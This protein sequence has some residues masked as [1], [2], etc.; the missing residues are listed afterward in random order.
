PYFGPALQ[1]VD[2]GSQVGVSSIVHDHDLVSI[3]GK[4]EADQCLQ[5]FLKPARATERRND[6]AEI[7]PHPRQAPLA[8]PVDESRHSRPGWPAQKAIWTAG[9]RR[10]PFSIGRAARKVHP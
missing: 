6:D 3:R 1:L 9:I 10:K 7:H 4:I 2:D 8:S 5:T